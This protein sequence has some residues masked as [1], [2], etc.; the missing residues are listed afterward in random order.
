MAERSAGFCDI[1]SGTALGFWAVRR[2]M[3]RRRRGFGFA[4]TLAF[5]FGLSVVSNLTFLPSTCPAVAV[6]IAV[7]K[8]ELGGCDT[9]ALIHGIISSVMSTRWNNF[10]DPLP[11]V[12]STERS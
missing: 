3:M 10:D 11:Q 1:E 7:S 5:A 9:S 2:R 6:S 8:T 12:Y 4:F